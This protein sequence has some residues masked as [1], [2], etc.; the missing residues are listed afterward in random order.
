[1]KIYKITWESGIVHWCTAQS[2]LHLLKSY[3]TNWDLCI[4]EIESIEEISEEEARRTMMLIEMETSEEPP[5]SLWD[6]AISA[7]DK[8]A[9]IA[10][11]A[12]E[13]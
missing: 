3:D 9:I 5:M 8:F 4:R 6:L 7:G 11:N 2:Q 1:M 13:D 10:S 12:F